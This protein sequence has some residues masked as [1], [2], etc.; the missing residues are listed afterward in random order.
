[1]LGV[2]VSPPAPA[3]AMDYIIYKVNSFQLRSI[4]VPLQSYLIM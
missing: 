4:F 1:M 3:L 2:R